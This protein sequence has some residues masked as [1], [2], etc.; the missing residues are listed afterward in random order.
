MRGK[1]IDVNELVD[2][3][4]IDKLK[5]AV[6]EY[7]PKDEV[8]EEIVEAVPVIENLETIVDKTIEEV[9]N[10]KED[11]EIYPPSENVV[12]EEIPKEIKKQFEEVEQII[13]QGQKVI[14]NTQIYE[15]ILLLQA[16]INDVS[17]NV[18]DKKQ[19]QINITTM[20]FDRLRFI[21]AHMS[22]WFVGIMIAMFLSGGVVFTTVYHNWDSITP[23]IDKLTSML[24]FANSAKRIVN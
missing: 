14:T 4:S 3:C 7:K 13:K 17:K 6:E 16:N 1:V 9:K 11:E 19:E 21:K 10:L 22:K 24:N 8:L 5:K 23:A 12:E 18:Q 15:M 20:I 2:S